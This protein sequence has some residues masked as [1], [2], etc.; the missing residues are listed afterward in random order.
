[1]PIWKGLDEGWK[2]CGNSFGARP[3]K[4]N[5]RDDLFVGTGLSLTPRKRATSTLEPRPKSTPNRP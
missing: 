5:F 4:K 2:D 3:L 1:L